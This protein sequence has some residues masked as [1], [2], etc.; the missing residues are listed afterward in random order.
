MDAILVR[1]ATDLK[2]IFVLNSAG[3][4]YVPGGKLPLRD[5]VLDWLL[6]ETGHVDDMYLQASSF[7]NKRQVVGIVPNP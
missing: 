4:C 6:N 1:T 3:S 2:P 7:G 5:F